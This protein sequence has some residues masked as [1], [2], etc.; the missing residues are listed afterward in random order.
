M[1]IALLGFADL[2]FLAIMSSLGLGVGLPMGSAN[3]FRR[4]AG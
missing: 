4:N 1:K 3:R 2:N